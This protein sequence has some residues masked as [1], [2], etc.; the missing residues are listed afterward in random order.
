MRVLDFFQS[1]LVSYVQFILERIP[2]AIVALVVGWLAI[3][4]VAALLGRM[5]RMAKVEPTI[6]QLGRSAVT[7]AGWIIVIAAV[8]QA[9]GLDQVALAVAGSIALIALAVATGASGTTGD[10]IAGVFL[11]SDPDFKAGY[12]VT[13]AGVTGVVERLDLRKTRI[14]AEDGKLNVVPNKA[15]ESA[16]W[17]VQSRG[18]GEA[19]AKG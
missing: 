7:V 15:V 12:A 2:S 3:K 18:E 14:R 19:K 8:L 13:A 11:A 1:T 16:T 9:L 5:L 4:L 10:I 17:V 6:A